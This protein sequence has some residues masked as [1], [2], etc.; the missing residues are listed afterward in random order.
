MRYKL[1]EK[2]L[3]FLNAD[4]WQWVGGWIKVL[5]RTRLPDKRRGHGVLLS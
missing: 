5:A 4:S 3:F 2:G 1:D